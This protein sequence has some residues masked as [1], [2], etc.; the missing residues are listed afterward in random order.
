MLGL[1]R[2]SMEQTRF[3]LIIWTLSV[4]IVR[5]EETC[6]VFR[7]CMKIDEPAAVQSRS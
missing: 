3:Q 5:L 4:M 6:V 2:D 7:T 1:L